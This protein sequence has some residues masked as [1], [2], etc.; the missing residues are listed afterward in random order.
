MGLSLQ[1]LSGM[2]AIGAGMIGYW[3]TGSAIGLS[4]FSR[5]AQ[6]YFLFILKQLQILLDWLFFYC[7]VCYSIHVT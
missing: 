1:Q 4:E 6:G 5:S 7:H 2:L 3:Y